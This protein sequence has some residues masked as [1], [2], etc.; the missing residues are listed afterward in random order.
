MASRFPDTYDIR[1][2]VS[3]HPAYSR[4]KDVQKQLEL[5][6]SELAHEVVAV[7]RDSLYAHAMSIIRAYKAAER[8]RDFMSRES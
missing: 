7:E 2:V 6:S 1:T 4:A 3:Y 8:L 5:A